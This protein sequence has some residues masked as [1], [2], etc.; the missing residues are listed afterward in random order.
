MSS[1]RAR[2]PYCRKNHQ[3]RAKFHTG[4]SRRDGVSGTRSGQA[5]NVCDDPVDRWDNLGRNGREA[6]FL[7]SGKSAAEPMMESTTAPNNRRSPISSTEDDG[8]I[9]SH[10]DDLVKL[11]LKGPKLSQWAQSQGILLPGK[12]YDV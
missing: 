8:E 5:G 12:L 3:H 9:L 11:G 6:S 4:L 2:W 1:D 10:V 7:R